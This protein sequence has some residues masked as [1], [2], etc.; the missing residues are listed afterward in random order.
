MN[1]SSD[2]FIFID[3]IVAFI[4]LSFVIVGFKKGLLFEVFSL[5]YTL[6]SI[7]VAWF[8]S[9]VLANL[10]PI[11]KLKD[12]TNDMQIIVE[13][14]NL[15]V[16]LN[17]VAYFVISFLVLKLCYIL[18]AVI[19]K[20]INKVPFVGGFNRIFGAII[21]GVNSLIII[22][23]LSMLLSTPII[24]N[25][26]EVK[27]NTVFKYIDTYSSKALNYIVNNSSFEHIKD[28]FDDFDVKA[29]RE[30]FK[31]WLKYKKYD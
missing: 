29:A 4:F 30:Q 16:L 6:A 24:K 21:G 3:I 12:L 8:L 7:V 18:L 5:V 23:I 11:I 20:G 22:F 13:F 25:G 17:T 28:E 2:L 1:I 27:Q 9:P 15:E 31:E 19:L 26:D 14:V 10:Y